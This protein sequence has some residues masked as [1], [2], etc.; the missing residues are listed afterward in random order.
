MFPNHNNNH[1]N[2]GHSSYQSD[3]YHNQNPYYLNLHRQQQQ[4]EYGL[5]H[6]A[7]MTV[8][9]FLHHGLHG[10]N[11]LPHYYPHHPTYEQQM[12]LHYYTQPEEQQLYEQQYAQQQQQHEYEYKQLQKSPPREYAK[13]KAKIK[14]SKK[15]KPIKST[16]PTNVVEITEN[17]IYD[18][19]MCSL[20]YKTREDRSTIASKQECDMLIPLS[21][22]DILNRNC[23]SSRLVF[24]A[25]QSVTKKP[26]EVKLPNI[27]TYDVI[28]G[29]IYRDLE[30]NRRFRDIISEN[31]GLFSS[32]SPAEKRELTV[33]MIDTI[34]DFGG[35][36]YTSNLIKA[37]S[38][39][40]FAYTF[41]SLERGFPEVLRP[42]LNTSSSSDD[43]KVID[44]EVPPMVGILHG[45][46][47][48]PSQTKPVIPS[49][50]TTKEKKET[51]KKTSS[52]NGLK[53]IDV[54]VPP[55]AVIPNGKLIWHDEGYSPSPSTV[56]E[57]KKVAKTLISQIAYFLPS[58][59]G[60]RRSPKSGKITPS[61]K[62]K[63]KAST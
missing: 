53:V 18:D 15:T 1:G 23:S 5:G 60:K 26:N 30:G 56:S 41:R 43:S 34:L 52:S 13:A 63:R 46:L 45:K 47:I 51:E 20:S 49:T 19:L 4:W 22:K 58:E 44:V 50:Q 16:K 55:M 31:R 6:S 59:N 38:E 35:Y 10:I 33:E 40:Y 2:T 36:F 17:S 3:V 9:T 39:E 28:L 62:R 37:T 11:H 57:T 7:P 24:E 42:I 32:A 21:I 29:D 25:D 54:E 12:H 48:W 27:S 14:T 61:S 8:G